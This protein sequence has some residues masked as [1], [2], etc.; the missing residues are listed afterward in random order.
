M[1]TN[2]QSLCDGV[3][4]SKDI[5]ES[6]Y[7]IPRQ[8]SISMAGTGDGTVAWLVKVKVK[9]YRLLV[10]ILARPL[11]KPELMPWWEKPARWTDSSLVV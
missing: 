11:R 5:S 10:L 4:I 1:S 7:L 2:F 3:H 8:L 6:E 9:V